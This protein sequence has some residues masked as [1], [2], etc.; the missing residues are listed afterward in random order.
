M[1]KAQAPEGRP[2]SR[3]ALIPVGSHLH[4]SAKIMP[5]REVIS[6]PSSPL[7]PTLNLRRDMDYSERIRERVAWRARDGIED[8]S[9]R[10]L[11][12]VI[13]LL[14]G[15]IIKSGHE[16]NTQDLFCSR[17]RLVNLRFRH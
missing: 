7:R 6:D 5:V 8:R 9:A 3:E 4:F 14:F 17:P 11:L 10:Y 2:R 12:I 16:E 1:N 13:C 15:R